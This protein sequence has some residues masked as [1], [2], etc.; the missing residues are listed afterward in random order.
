[1]QI[2]GG[3]NNDKQNYYVLLVIKV[4]SRIY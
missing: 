1:M 4:T 2:L 3:K